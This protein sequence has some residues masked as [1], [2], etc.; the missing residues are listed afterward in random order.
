M[1]PDLNLDKFKLFLP[2]YLSPNSQE[3]LFAC[4]RDFP[5]NID[6]RFYT[7]HLRNEEILFQGDGVKDLLVINLPEPEIKPVP[8]LILS[9]TC[10][11]YVDEERRSKSRLIYAP[12]VNLKKYRDGLV[13]SGLKSEKDVENHIKS[14]KNQF[15]SNILYLP[16]LNDNIDESIVFL[17]RINNCDRDFLSSEKLKDLR[18]FSLSNYGHYMLVFKLSLH[19]SRIIENYDRTI[20]KS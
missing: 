18:V 15:V 13:N 5:N 6:S 4:L 8:S 3:E 17:D 2:K 20:P 9:N 10:D 19:F 11:I 1:E 14:I 7:L 12:I 16:K